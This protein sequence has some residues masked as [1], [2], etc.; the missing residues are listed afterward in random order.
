MSIIKG[1]NLQSALRI[2]EN[3]Y[4]KADSSTKKDKYD[5]VEYSREELDQHVWALQGKRDQQNIEAELRQREEEEE[6]FS[7]VA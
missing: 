3:D 1:L 4:R 5:N 7:K 2:I 6:Y